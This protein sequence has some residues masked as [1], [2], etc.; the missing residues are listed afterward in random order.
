MN[1]YLGLTII[2]IISGLSAGVI[3]GGANINSTITHI[4]WFIG[5]IKK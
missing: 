3:G 2:G 1:Y 4:I 5:I